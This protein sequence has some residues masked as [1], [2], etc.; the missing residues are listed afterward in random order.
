MKVRHTYIKCELLV[1]V[2]GSREPE[3]QELGGESSVREGPGR[4][5]VGALGKALRGRSEVGKCQEEEARVG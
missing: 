2:N 1:S 5:E 4:A 3:T